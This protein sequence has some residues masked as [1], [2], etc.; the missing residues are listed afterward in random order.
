L[1]PFPLSSLTFSPSKLEYLSKDGEFVEVPRRNYNYF[2]SR[3][4]G[5][6]PFTFRITDIYGHVIIEENI[7]LVLDEIVDGENQ[8][9]Y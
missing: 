9:P 2:E 4:Y 3:E 8:F 7:P 6:G 5:A 1:C